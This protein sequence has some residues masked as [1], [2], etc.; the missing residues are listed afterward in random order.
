VDR[1]LSAVVPGENPINHLLEIFIGVA[2][3]LLLFRRVGVPKDK[4]N[5]PK[6]GDLK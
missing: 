3:M 2:P 5:E 6:G 4:N 1:S